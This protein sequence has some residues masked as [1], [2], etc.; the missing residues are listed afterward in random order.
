MPSTS[1][2][3]MAE[4][5]GA[6]EGVNKAKP[7]KLG[8]DFW[9]Y[10]SGQLTSQ[11]GSSFTMFVL[12]LLVYRLTKSSMGLAYTTVA[13]FV[14]YLLFGL[15]LGA[16]VDRLPRRQL[17]MATDIAR[18]LVLLALPLLQ[19]TGYLRVWEIYVVAFLQS[20]LGI[21]FNCGEFAAIP[22]LVDQTNLVAANGRIMATNSAGAVVGPALAGVLVP[23]ISMSGLLI[24]DACTFFLSALTL[25]LIHRSFDAGKEGEGP[26]EKTTIRSD[27]KEGLAYVW[28][29]PVLRSISIM[30]ALV[31]FVGATEG[32]QLV[33]YAKSVLHTGDVG[34]AMLFAAGAAGVVI[35]GLAAAPIRRQFSFVVCCLGTL[36]ISGLAVSLM[37]VIG[38]FPAAMILWGVS[39]GF[40]LFL[41]INTSTLRQTIVPARLYGRVISVAGVVAWSAI[42]LGALAGAAAIRITGNVAGVYFVTGLLTALIAIAFSFSP[43]RQ[44]GRYM[45]E[46]N[47]RSET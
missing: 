10:F 26:Q 31:N 14:P 33:L 18:G 37:A 30:M 39:A 2:S 27:V 47:Q 42:P 5:V 40:G 24:T 36:V 19:L 20:S 21:L 44:G 16:L 9:L 8:R 28:A 38:T 35:V 34:T 25:A 1:V 4:A 43:I 45:D 3:P 17:M 29:N 41:N 11:L 32:S 13:E 22:S 12:P 23:F 46:A 15:V 6:I 7:S